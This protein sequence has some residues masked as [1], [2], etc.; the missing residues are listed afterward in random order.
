MRALPEALRN[1]DFNLRARGNA[2]AENNIFQNIGFLGTNQPKCAL[3]KAG[4]EKT[5]QYCF[6][7]CPHARCTK[8]QASSMPGHATPTPTPV[9]EISAPEFGVALAFL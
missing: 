1:L 3:K 9:Q 8:A 6:P 7:S 2:V 5:G 4:G